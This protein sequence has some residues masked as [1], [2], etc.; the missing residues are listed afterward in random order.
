MFIHVLTQKNMMINIIFSIKDF[1]AASYFHLLS[2]AHCFRIGI[3]I[4]QMNKYLFCNV[5]SQQI[6]FML[7]R[8]E[9]DCP[10]DVK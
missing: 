2:V 9:C 10:V 8:C 7:I 3:E 4:R 1:K 6:L 5:N